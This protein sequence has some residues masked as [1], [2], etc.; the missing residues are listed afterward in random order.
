MVTVCDL[1]LSIR[2][3]I[4]AFSSVC[5][6]ASFS[7]ISFFICNHLAFSACSLLF[8]FNCLSISVATFLAC[9]SLFIAYLDVSSLAI[10]S[11]SISSSF[12]TFYLCFLAL[13][14]GLILSI[15]A[16]CLLANFASAAFCL[17][18]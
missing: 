12:G 5:L 7:F 2:A 4:L 6:L 1:C 18:F 14:L 3:A 11:I 10:L 17:C 8:S 13:V 16:K 15:F 9:K